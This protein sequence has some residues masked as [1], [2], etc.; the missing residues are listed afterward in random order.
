MLQSM[1]M[2]EAMTAKM[3]VLVKCR[4]SDSLTR[5]LRRRS[6]RVV[7]TRAEKTHQQI[8]LVENVQNITL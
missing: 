5:F 2:T 8:E 4:Y 1:K 7:W 6:V 3:R